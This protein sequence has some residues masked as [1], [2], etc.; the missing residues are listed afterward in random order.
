[1]N[2]SDIHLTEMLKEL[3]SRSKIKIVL[4]AGLYALILFFSVVGNAAT[5]V[6]VAL[7]SRMRTIPNLFVASLAITDLL[8]GILVTVPI[9]F[10][11]LVLSKYPF[12]DRTCQY[13]GYIV[14]V[15]AVASMQTMAL[16]AVNRFYR[17]V[18]SSNWA[19]LPYILSSHKMVFHPFKFFC[20]LQIDSGPFMA[21]MVTVYIGLPTL[22]V[23][24]C[25]LRI[26]ETVRSHN[27]NVHS[28][29]L[30]GNQLNVE[31][32]KTARLL[33]IIVL[34]FNICWTPV[35]L[36]DIVDTLN[37]K[38]IFPRE[39]YVAYSF[40]ATVSGSLNPIIYGLLN[41]NFRREYL[42]VFRRRYC[43]NRAKIEPSVVMERRPKTTQH[44]PL[45]KR[46]F[47]RKKKKK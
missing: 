36:I 7:N 33:F 27:D 24:Y 17:I 20:Y 35:M 4:E 39:T 23:M 18:H 10:P 46:S 5:L 16:M 47:S 43:R 38:W 29:A 6:V 21:Y 9:C 14:I 2:S 37:G 26:F 1:M 3:N 42:K 22:V 34:F 13:H 40:L 28:I 41:K 12:S 44:L 31:E 45:A 15:L 25:Y 19:P 11:T 32:I 8:L 30:R